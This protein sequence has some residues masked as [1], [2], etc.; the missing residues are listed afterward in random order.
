MTTLPEPASTSPEEVDR[1]FRETDALAITRA[2]RETDDDALEQLLG[3]E[4]F[5]RA[6]VAAILER[7]PEF[8]DPERLAEIHGSVCFDL[9]GAHG[10]HERYLAT[11]DDGSV[12]Y[13]E[14]PD[15]DAAD[16]T[17][18]SGIVCFVRLVTGQR[19][20]ALLYLADELTIGGDG[21]LALAV[22]SVFRVPGS[23]AAVVDPTA[24]DPVEVSRAITGVS[25]KHLHEVMAGPFRELVVS[26]V[27]RRMPDY[28]IERK[29]A[30]AD[31][32]IGFR[33][34]GRPDGD[35]DR[36]VVSVCEGS[37][38]ISREPGED[39][40]RDATLVVDGPTFLR[41][42]LGHLN[43]VRALLGGKLGLKGDRA[44][45]LAFNALMDIPRPG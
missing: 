22:G 34:E 11:F 17:I 33:I 24:L 7:F 16:V 37:C 35:A 36:F 21:L 29:A 18:G 43:P 19:N 38:T 2:I 40:R 28:L 8:A 4:A 9:A 12:T 42:V 23:D 5:R 3:E 1:W 13:V 32:A 41:L 26:E 44:R 10:R 45:A 6:G 14:D 39:V 20:A 31:V 30:R 25:T 27:F 15:D